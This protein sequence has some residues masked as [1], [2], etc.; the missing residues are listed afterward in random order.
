MPAK[1]YMF[2]SNGVYAP[3]RPAVPPIASASLGVVTM[4]V[5][6][7]PLN[8]SFISRV[9]NAKSGCGSCGRH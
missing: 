8:G 5:K 1:M 9:H 6:S 2:L 7:I 3:A 4:P